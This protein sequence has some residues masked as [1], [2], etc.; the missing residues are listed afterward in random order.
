MQ[1]L[2]TVEICEV[3]LL[4][5]LFYATY[6]LS[7]DLDGQPEKNLKNYSKSTSSQTIFNGRKLS[8][9]GL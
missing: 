7:G 6:L 4:C 8:I 3:Q 5:S 9:I 1:I 2:S